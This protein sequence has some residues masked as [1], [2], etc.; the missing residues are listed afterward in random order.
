MSI[1]LE[2]FL[3]VSSFIAEFLGTVRF[4][5]VLKMYGSIPTVSHG[6]A[7]T[8]VLTAF[9]LFN[10]ITYLGSKPYAYMQHFRRYWRHRVSS[11]ADK[12]LV[13]SSPM[14]G[15]KVAPY[16][17][18]TQLIGPMMCDDVIQNT[19]TLLLI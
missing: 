1:A 6:S 18:I 13:Q 14:E 7:A 15:F 9:I 16:G 2:A 5:A 3:S 4:Y 17:I 19:I 12:L 10:V 8:V 11:K